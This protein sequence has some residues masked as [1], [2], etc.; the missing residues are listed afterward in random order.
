MNIL[1]SYAATALAAIGGLVIIVA[2]ITQLT[3]GLPGIKSIPTEL[4]AI[5]LSE[6][7]TIASVCAY[8]S[9]QGINIEWYMVFGTIIGGVCVAYVASYGWDSFNNIVNRYKK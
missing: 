2:F 8:C 4:Y 5:V 6:L 3:K 7:I 9:W 1:I